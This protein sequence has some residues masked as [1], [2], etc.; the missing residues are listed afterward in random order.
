MLEQEVERLR[1][2]YQRAKEESKNLIEQMESFLKQNH[3]I[4]QDFLKTT[5][6]TI[7]TLAKP[8]VVKP[9]NLKGLGPQQS[10]G[11]M[12]AGRFQVRRKT[13]QDSANSIMQRPAL[14]ANT[15]TMNGDHQHPPEL[16]LPTLKKLQA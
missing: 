3:V 6:K 5:Q 9:T 11:Q 10:A 1:G 8:P 14:S 15:N 12:D 7:N 13:F 16:W 4:V 2:D